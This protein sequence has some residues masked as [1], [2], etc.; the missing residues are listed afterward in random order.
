[1][2]IKLSD[3]ILL[4]FLL[5]LP[6]WNS[7]AQDTITV[8]PSIAR[9]DVIQAALVMPTQQAT[10]TPDEAWPLLQQHADAPKK[11]AVGF[12]AN[13]FWIGFSAFNP[14]H[15]TV[16]Q[17]I[18]VDNPQIDWLYVYERDSS[19]IFT[20]LAETGDK[21]LFAQRPILHRNFAIPLTFEPGETKS[22]LIKI[23]KRNSSLVM[24]VYL[25]DEK[26]FHEKTYTENLRFGI[27]FGIIGLCLIYALMA[28]LFLRQAI[29]GWYF[30]L[31]FVTAVYL[32]TALG[33]SFQ[34][35][36]PNLLDFNSYLRVYV[37]VI[38]FFCIVKFSQKFLSL[39]LHQ[40][41]LNRVIN[42]LLIFLMIYF[43]VSFFTLDFMSRHSL[44][45]IPFINFFQLCSGLLLVVAAI[46]SYAQQPVTVAIYFTAWGTLM[47]GYAIMTISEFG[48]IPVEDLPVHPVLVGSSM[49]ILIFSVGLTYQIRK[50]YNERNQLSLNMAKQQKE[51]LKAYV[52]GSEKERER[53]ARELHD[54]IGSRLGSLKRFITTHTSSNET[55][56]EQIDI[57]CR[58]VRTMS[59]Q[60]TPPS[61][62]ITGLRQLIRQLV[63]ETP[64][65]NLRLDVQFYDV[66]E[67]LPAETNHHLYRIVQE[68]IANVIK[69]AGATEMDIQFFVHENELVMTLDD[70][71]KGFN[72]HQ[73]SGGIGLQNMRTRTEALNGQLEISSSPG[74]GTNIL[75][76]IPL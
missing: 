49:E 76:R 52:E 55:L 46:R 10:L 38:L 71:G 23:D 37:I 61:M 2:T 51:L 7:L 39:T 31:V 26:T 8:S 50:V 29:F 42:Y 32:F 12:T 27:F 19:G 70:N 25:W 68:A 54:D 45:F 18:E 3:C 56:E 4:A 57:L 28:F 58:D 16:N 48:W 47:M 1:M 73:Q 9:L 5:C 20:L 6:V 65:E 53:I 11:T 41:R 21:F 44:I 34:Y 14:S 33:F 24:P 69:H 59:H 74:N 67:N 62:R 22:I 15:I 75:I 36:Y 30:V 35:V 60:L 64:Q 13:I 63:D 72:V 17:I 40:P 43:F 66:P